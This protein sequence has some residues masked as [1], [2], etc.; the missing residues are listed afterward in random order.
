MIES[1]ISPVDCDVAA[2]HTH[3]ADRKQFRARKRV[4]NARHNDTPNFVDS[5][6]STVHCSRCALDKDVVIAAPLDD[7]RPNNATTPALQDN[8]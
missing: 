6:V 5:R 7:G 3:L 2:A 1:L 4:V 8:R